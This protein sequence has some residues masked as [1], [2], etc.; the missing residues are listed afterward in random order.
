MNDFKSA[1]E[2]REKYENKELKVI[3]VVKAFLEKIRK[4]DEKIGAYITLCEEEALKEVDTIEKRMNTLKQSC[5]LK[6]CLGV[7]VDKE[8]A[9]N[10]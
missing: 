3:D 4:D 10:K 5:G 9:K 8:L 7:A 6:Y 2:I 1:G